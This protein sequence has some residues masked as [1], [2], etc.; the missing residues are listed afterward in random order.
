M[1]DGRSANGPEGSRRRSGGL[2]EPSLTFLR[3]KGIPI[4]A[5]WT[6][7]FVF[8][9]VLWALGSALFPRTYPGLATTTYWVMAAVAAVAFF[10]SV[11]LH[12]LG[13]A[14]RALRHGVH[15]EGITLWLFGGVA[16][17]RHLFPS[18]RAEFAIAIAGPLV[19][20]GLVV[21]FGLLAWGGG[22]L[23]WGDPAVG[24]LDY[25]A[26]INGIVL[27]FNLVPALPLDGGRVLRAYLWHRQGDFAAATASSALAGRIFGMLLIGV[28][29]LGLFTGAG[30]GGI[31]IAFI[32]WFLLQAAQA[33]ATHAILRQAF[34][35]LTVRE[36]MTP[37]PEAVP[38]SMSVEDFL[39]RAGGPRGHSTYPV[40]EGGRLAGMVSLRLAGRVRP[41][42]RSRTA[43]ADV[44]VPRGDVPT[45]SPETGIEETLQRLQEGPGRALVTEDGAVAGILSRS[46]LA[47]VLERRQAVGV[48]GRPG[49]RRAGFAVWVVVGLAMLIA[50]SFLYHPPVVAVAPGPAVAIDE[51]ITIRGAAVSEV[52][53]D[54]LL[55]S[56]KLSQ[57]S[58]LGALWSLFHPDRDLVPISSV[59]PEGVDPER[60]AERQREV[61][62]QSRQVAAIAA[63]RALGMEVSLS[64]SGAAV[65][66]VLPNSPA[67][68]ALEPEDVIVAIEGTEIELANEV[69]DVIRGRPAGTTFE[70]TIERDGARRTVRV[71]S[72]RLDPR[73]E[74]FTGIGVLLRTRD[75][76]ADLPFEIDFAERTV[77][78]PSAGLAYALAIADLLSPTDYAAG[79]VIAATGTI[80]I[81]GDVGRVGGLAKK[82]DGAAGQGAALF[83]VPEAE[84]AAARG[85]GVDVRGVGRLADALRVLQ[86]TA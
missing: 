7:V 34:E 84:V 29:I 2:F 12:E 46:D 57:P 75:F 50:V 68:R 21:A 67:A 72:T 9:L 48:P 28:G 58:A 82:A 54:Y 24:V 40:I 44:M 37:D 22:R 14:L 86:A 16:R 20:L 35:G 66:A 18:A 38:P 8:G 10:G 74:G 80:S 53:G 19:S 49:P 11:L 62:R 77:G 60:F 69:A 45:I 36:V 33:E 73:A 85:E 71:T 43:I 32:G 83:I 1:A 42:E 70:M 81:D 26:R 65:A 79:R 52:N 56:V 61:F 15:I 76:Q 17:F 47:R 6:W 3:V 41:E 5:H 39:Q 27:G 51:E 31:W 63:A 64:G 78:G 30:T 23:G 25:L 13:H 4:G 55:T 59:I